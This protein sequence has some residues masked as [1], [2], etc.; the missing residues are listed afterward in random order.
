[1]FR[2]VVGWIVADR[3]I[4]N[5]DKC[6]NAQEQKEMLDNFQNYLDNA[7]ACKLDDACEIP[8]RTKLQMCR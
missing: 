4:N 8:A 2:Y 1:M 5:F 3:W 6:E 7:H